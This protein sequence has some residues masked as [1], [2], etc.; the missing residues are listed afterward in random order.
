MCA[1]S[2][3]FRMPISGSF[4]NTTFSFGNRNFYALHGH[5]RVSEFLI[6]HKNLTSCFPQE[7]GNSIFRPEM[8]ILRAGEAACSRAG[9]EGGVA[10]NPWNTHGFLYLWGFLE[11][12]LCE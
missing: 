5:P 11:Q 4:Q 7:T 6:Q 10:P 1:D 12:N 3:P 9:S 2:P 8:D